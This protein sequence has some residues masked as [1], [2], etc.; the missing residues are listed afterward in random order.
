MRE[1][2][3]SLTSTDVSNL[4]D[5]KEKYYVK[6]FGNLINQMMDEDPLKR[7]TTDLILKTLSELKK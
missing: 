5:P 6:Y 7:P 3:L 4:F 2:S 1:S